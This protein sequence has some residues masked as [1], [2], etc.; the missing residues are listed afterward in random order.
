VSL[1]EKEVNFSAPDSLV[2]PS[3]LTTPGD[4]RCFERNVRWGKMVHVDQ[5]AAAGVL[6]ALHRL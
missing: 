3:A 6:G 1:L 5:G 4:Q 2:F